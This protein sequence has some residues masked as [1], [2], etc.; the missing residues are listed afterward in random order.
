MKCIIDFKGFIPITKGFLIP[1][2]F[3]AC[4]TAINIQ[5]RFIREFPDGF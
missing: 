4:I 5:S 2:K 1:A 3:L